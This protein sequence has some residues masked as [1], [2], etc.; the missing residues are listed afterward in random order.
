MP[1][2][3]H[4]TIAVGSVTIVGAA[5]GIVHSFVALKNE[6]RAP[7]QPTSPPIL[8]SPTEE[9]VSRISAE[10][11]Q[12]Q[13][14]LDERYAARQGSVLKEG[15]AR[16]ASSPPALNCFTIPFGGPR[17]RLVLWL[18]VAIIGVWVV[19]SSVTPA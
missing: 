15:S 13:R 4:L 3:E 10:Q 11:R 14:M 2:S 6:S 5:F 7:K 1:T 8:H 18:L 16:P 17:L 9:E 19:V 12:Y